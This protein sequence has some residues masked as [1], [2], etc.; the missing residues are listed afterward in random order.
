MKRIKNKFANNS[1]SITSVILVI[2]LSI[3]LFSS[4]VFFQTH[5]KKL[6]NDFINSYELNVEYL[7]AKLDLNVIS[8]NKNFVLT[9]MK[10]RLNTGTFK[11]LTL[12]YNRFIFNK[13]SLLN[14]TTE[15]INKSWSI[16]EIIVDARYGLINSIP[17]T[18]IYEFIPSDSFDITKPISIRYQVYKKEELKSIIA[19]IDFSN[20]QL[21]HKSNKNI[22]TQ[23]DSIIN[24]N[25]KDI[26]YDIKKDGLVIATIVY[27]VDTIN[28]RKE[29]E[30]LL[31]NLILLTSILFIPVIFLTVFYHRYI[32]NNY[33][34][35]PVI[36]LNEYLD[37]ILENKFTLLDKNNLEGTKEIKE[38]TKKVT[39]V[40]SKIASLKNELNINKESLELKA[41]TDSLTGLPNKNIFDFDIKTM[42]VSLI[43]GYV[44]I[45]KID[46]L[47]KFS[48]NHDSG[49]INSFIESYVNIVKNIIF[50][51]SKIDI[52]L[53]R[54][55]G[56][57]FAI[58]AK[59]INIEKAKK[60]C[61]EIIEELLDRM[62]DIYDIP[63]DL[64]QIGGSSFDLYGSLDTILSSANHAYDISTKQ[65]VNSYYIV[66]E[67]D[68]EKNYSL[69]DN[70]VVE[71]IEKADFDIFFILDSFSFDDPD[72]LVMS[73]VL[74]QL[75]DHNNKKIS[76]GSFVSV[77][78]KLNIVDSFDKLVIEKTIDCIKK[79]NFMHEISINLS[80]SSIEN[81]SF[82][83]WLENTLN[84]NQTVL[85][86]LVFS[87]TSYTAYL[88]KSAF[89]NFVHDIHSIGAKVLLKRYK[90]DEYPLTSLDSLELDYIRINKDYTANFSKDIAKKHK[91]K[92][93]IIYAELNNI[94]V[95]TDSVKIDSDY[96][97]LERL[98]IYA[99]SR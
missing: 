54:F 71:V 13:D 43:K 88:H 57:Q 69:L 17:N 6:V 68:I 41:S 77:A 18:N 9:E 8:N 5:K 73:E 40:S 91:V 61:E 38:L 99:T 66:G 67:K 50:K 14:N 82:I 20:I 59:N 81:P 10:R 93:I 74:P 58:I 84:K 79:N 65:G 98:G 44:F 28:L 45:L 62:P 22:T 46:G 34:R 72:K 23:I 3:F 95:I 90:T 27:K 83:K 11:S 97:L 64:V 60:M 89:V 4:Y 2:F 1:S 49:Y 36:Y 15:S 70:T 47:S 19:K 85:N 51:Y 96:D 52:K 87:I 92:N 80:I 75:F 31:I 29:L 21:N 26:T 35:K 76:I 30:S 78:Q 33:V 16:A 55:Y 86:K 56:S 12:D 53:Y 37:N 24:L 48:E 7:N 39:K 63:K 25:I 32:F 94:K 42:F